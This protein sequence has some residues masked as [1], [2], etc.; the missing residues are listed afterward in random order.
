VS[1]S[2]EPFAEGALRYAFSMFD[3]TC[4]QELVAK[5]PKVIDEKNYT[6]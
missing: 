4:D 3:Y 6:L 5:L 1:I 2:I